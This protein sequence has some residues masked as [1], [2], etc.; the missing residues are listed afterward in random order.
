L[1]RAKKITLPA[2]LFQRR[3]QAASRDRTRRQP[4]GFEPFLGDNG[5]KNVHAGNGANGVME[6]WSGG[7]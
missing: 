3:F 2:A 4:G 1:E 7:A 5:V 6:W